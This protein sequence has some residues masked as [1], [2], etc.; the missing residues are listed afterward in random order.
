MDAALTFCMR[1]TNIK[2][3]RNDSERKMQWPKRNQ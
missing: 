1:E 3:K 2:N